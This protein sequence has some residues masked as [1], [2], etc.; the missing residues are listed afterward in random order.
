MLSI[1][2]MNRDSTARNNNYRSRRYDDNEQERYN[3][4]DSDRRR[5]KEGD[6]RESKYDRSPSTQQET[7]AEEPKKSRT[8]SRSKS[9]NCRWDDPV[10]LFSEVNL[11]IGH[12]GSLIANNFSISLWQSIHFFIIFS[13]SLDR[14]T[15]LKRLQSTVLHRIVL[16][17]NPVVNGTELIVQ[18]GLKLNTLKN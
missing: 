15:N 17:S 8:T 16:I 3:E 5:G 4:K 14:S 7:R 11:I 18:M 1:Q 13:F 2:P 12:F 10:K 6:R 9:P